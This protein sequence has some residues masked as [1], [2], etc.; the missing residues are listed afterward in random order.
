MAVRRDVLA[1]WEPALTP[2]IVAQKIEWYVNEKLVKRV[3]IGAR[4][5]VRSWLKDCPNIRISEG[6]TIKFTVCS[7]DELGCSSTVEEELLFARQAPDAPDDLEL[8]KELKYR[9]IP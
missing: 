3:Y 8:T 2:D 5:R 4:V 9:S 7:V 1:K 6:D